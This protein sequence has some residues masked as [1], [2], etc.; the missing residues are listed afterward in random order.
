MACKYESLSCHSECSADVADSCLVTPVSRKA[1]ILLCH[2]L[3]LS[4]LGACERVVWAADKPIYTIACAV[5]R[6]LLLEG[7][8]FLRFSS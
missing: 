5:N 8:Y 3:M 1:L 6:S 2:E 4:F 7:Q